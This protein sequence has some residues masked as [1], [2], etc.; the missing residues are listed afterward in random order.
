MIKH[1]TEVWGK[2]NGNN[3]YLHDFSPRA[4]RRSRGTAWLV[5]SEPRANTRKR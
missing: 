3:H 1:F 5:C 4:A 2:E